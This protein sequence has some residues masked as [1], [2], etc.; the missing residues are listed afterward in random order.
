MMLNN[1]DS[2]WCLT[3]TKSY[4][5]NIYKS[6][7]YVSNL[8]YFHLY[9]RVEYDFDDKSFD[10]ASSYAINFIESLLQKRPE[11]RLSAQEVIIQFF[12][13]WYLSWKWECFLMFHNFDNMFF[14]LGINLCELC[15]FYFQKALFFF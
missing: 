13:I 5:R 2:F 10:N 8:F 4:V 9:S 7:S 6:V 1:R 3:K 12:N 14:F 11:H 15:N